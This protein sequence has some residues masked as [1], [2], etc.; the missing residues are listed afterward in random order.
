[1]GQQRL[2]SRRHIQILALQRCSRAISLVVME[3]LYIPENF[4][5]H[6]A[7]YPYGV[8]LDYACTDIAYRLRVRLANLS[9]REFP[10]DVVD[11]EIYMEERINLHG[12]GG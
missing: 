8:E 3:G 4:P 1:V 2:Y 7:D 12:M 10:L 9:V 11:R 6:G 5:T